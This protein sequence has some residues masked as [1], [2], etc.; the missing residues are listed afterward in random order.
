MRL[1]F[2]RHGESE[3][4]TLHVISNR[5][6]PFGLTALGK[7]QANILADSLKDIP[8]TVIFSSPILRAR[9][10]ADILSQ[11]LSQPYQI[12]E[13]LR[14]Y[15]CGILEDKSDDASWRMH[16]EIAE[17]WTLHHKWQ[18]KPDGGESFLDIQNRFLPFIK[19]L[20]HD[21]L[22]ANRHILFVGHG[23]LFQLMLPLLLTNID[24]DFVRSHGINHTD[25]IIAEQQPAG[26]VCLQWA[27]SS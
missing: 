3:A 23:G 7:K 1:Y 10:T 19:A 15:D 22:D 26:L 11:S 14:E 20:T 18:R 27:R 12:T 4:N 6:S 25:C 5:E 2:V 9:E 21:S 24:D 8:V 17:D 13:A 16:R